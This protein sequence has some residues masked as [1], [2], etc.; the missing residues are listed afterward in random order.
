[1]QVV[2]ALED[3]FEFDLIPD[4]YAVNSLLGDTGFYDPGS[5]DRVRIDRNQV[6]TSGLIETEGGDIVIGGDHPQ[7][8]AACSLGDMG[9]SID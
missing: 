2:I 6:E 3:H 1:M 4:R 8:V 9:H 7:S 5:L